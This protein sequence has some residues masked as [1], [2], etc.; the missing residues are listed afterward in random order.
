MRLNSSLEFAYVSH[1][2]SIRS[3]TSALVSFMVLW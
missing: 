2:S 1:V 3:L